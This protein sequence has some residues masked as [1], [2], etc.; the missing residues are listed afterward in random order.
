M[1]WGKN[2]TIYEDHS[3]S[4]QEGWSSKTKQNKDKKNAIGI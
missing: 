1:V 2:L 3:W 4:F